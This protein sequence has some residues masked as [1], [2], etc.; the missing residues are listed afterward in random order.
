MIIIIS[1]IINR[2]NIAVSTIITALNIHS[3]L[4]PLIAGRKLWDGPK[5]EAVFKKWVA[6][7]KKYRRVLSAEAV[8]LAHGTLCW[9]K[10]DP[11]PNSTCSHTG[12]DATL[13]RAPMAYYPD[14]AERALAVV[15]NPTATT[16]TTTL[17]A[18]L[19]VVPITDCPIAHSNNRTSCP[20]IWCAHHPAAYNQ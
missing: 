3:S 17:L 16:Q 12:L 11:H 5:S 7:A 1:C 13:H 4:W 8:T 18:P 6:W 2:I 9:G 19:F 15:W 20:S 10:D 14:I